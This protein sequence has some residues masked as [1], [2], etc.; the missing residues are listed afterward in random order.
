MTTSRRTLSSPRGIAIFATVCAV[1]IVLPL[2]SLVV[3]VPW[4]T[5]WSTLS[6]DTSQTALWLSLRTS[7]ITTVLAIFSGLP[8]AW[9]LAHVQFRFKTLIRAVCV[10][11]MVL[12]P[13]VGG[14]ALLYAFG[15]RGVVGSSLDDWFGIRIAFT[16]SAAVLAQYFV[17]VPFF[18]VVMESA[19]QQADPRISDAARTLGAGPWRTLLRVVL[20]GMKPAFVAAIA[21]TW[22]RALGEFGATISFAGNSPGRTQTLPLAIYSSLEAGNDEALTLSFIMMIVSFS[23]LVALR[24]RWLG[25]LRRGGA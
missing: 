12:P 10:L 17:A 13:V 19:F 18:V 2:G 15:R 6:S 11:P 16:Q 21:L 14:V 7:F 5:F 25:A 3:R 23:V 4:S 20:P 8:L 22:A 9:V 24:Q 1:L